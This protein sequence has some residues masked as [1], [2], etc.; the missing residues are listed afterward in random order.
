MNTVNGRTWVMNLIGKKL[1]KRNK[2]K[3]KISPS[4]SRMLRTISIH[5][6]ECN[7]YV[8]Q[9]EVG[10]MAKDN[11]S[12]KVALNCD[13]SSVSEHGL[14]VF[15]ETQESVN[16]KP[17]EAC[18]GIDRVDGFLGPHYGL[19]KIEN[20]LQDEHLF[21]KGKLL[22][23]RDALLK[24]K[25]D[26]PKVMAN[27]F[28]IQSKNFLDALV[29]FNANRDAL[30]DN[31]EDPNYFSPDYVEIIQS[32]AEARMLI[33]S[34]SFPVF[35][36]TSA[37]ILFL[38]HKKME[39]DFFV[40]QR[41]K[42]KS[43]S[44]FINI[45][46]VSSNSKGFSHSHELRKQ[47]EAGNV[48]NR[49]RNLKQRI[50]DVIMVNRKEKNQISLDGI[51]HRV[52]FGHKLL[53]DKKLNLGDDPVTGRHDGDS[54]ES[55][56]NNVWHDSYRKFP[57]DCFQRSHSLSESLDRYSQLFE[58]LSLNEKR[59][60]PER[61]K[62][63][64]EDIGLPKLSKNF[65][66]MMSSPVLRS[67]SFSKD[68]QSDVYLESS[69]ALSTEPL[70]RERENFV[71]SK[72][73]QEDSDLQQGKLPKN[74]GRMLSSPVFRSYSFSEVL[75]GAG[76]FELTKILT[77]KLLG[78]EIE[79]NVD[80][81]TTDA[82]ISPILVK[83]DREHEVG[84]E[85]DIPFMVEEALSS[86]KFVMPT[87]EGITDIVE[88]QVI[89][90]PVDGSNQLMPSFDTEVMVKETDLF[91]RLKTQTKAESDVKPKKSSFISSLDLNVVE[92][93][94]SSAKDLL[95]K[96][97]QPICIDTGEKHQLSDQNDIN[98]NEHN[99]AKHSMPGSTNEQTVRDA[100]SFLIHVD[101]KDGTLFKFVR[102]ILTK[103]GTYKV[104]NQKTE[105]SYEFGVDLYGTPFEQHLLH[106]LINEVLLEIYENSTVPNPW[107]LLFHSKIRSKPEGNYLLKDVWDEVSWHLH[108]PQGFDA[109]LDDLMAHAFSRN[110][111]WANIYRNAEFV[112]LQL[113]HLILDDLLD[114]TVMNSDKLDF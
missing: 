64:R 60:A 100:S 96:E 7:D 75:E 52:P 21:L 57:N 86:D 45:T 113:E 16:G 95:P 51:L 38:A 28:A 94:T 32:P 55:K 10:Q 27:E 53:E 87:V 88:N 79:R 93:S 66:R 26:N 77:P 1:L 110:D 81:L 73:I 8:P 108:S 50:K 109:T 18:R 24:Q 56:F 30:L 5:H 40:N 22:E 19:E 29:L 69:K 90:V 61:S 72:S 114:E 54:E 14:L 2:H 3:G 58:T 67:F 34:T 65:G 76:Y 85:P 13:S 37:G 104:P 9:G 43:T 112:A 97:L 39:S 15:K 70:G 4:S 31:P 111:G 82:I 107:L 6:L 89:P 92:G 25:Y 98:C 44:S 17:S 47:K 74:F 36:I 11:E 84:V 103:S 63:I 46:G 49:S 62:S 105:F 68:V 71:E 106:D 20:H 59:E 80:K 42:Y 102:Y 99:F 83:K 101:H 41:T 12:L 78:S 23:A 48:V 91:S 33:K 35:F